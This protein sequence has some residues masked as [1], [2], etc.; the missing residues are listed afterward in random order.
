MLSPQVQ[1]GREKQKK[2]LRNDYGRYQ[3]PKQEEV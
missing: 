1:T 2:E 3:I